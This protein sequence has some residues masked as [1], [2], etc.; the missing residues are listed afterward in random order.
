VTLGAENMFRSL[1]NI[2][3]RE[4]LVPRWDRRWQ[5]D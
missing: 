5:G 4:K 2:V 3:L 1:E